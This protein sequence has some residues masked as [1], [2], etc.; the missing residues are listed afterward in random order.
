MFLK[1]TANPANIDSAGL[2]DQSTVLCDGLMC[3]N[4]PFN[5]CLNYNVRLETI[6]S[7]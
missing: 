1:L 7:S 4:L 3:N 6:V 5:D 2:I